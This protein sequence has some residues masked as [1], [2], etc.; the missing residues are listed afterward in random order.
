MA[1]TPIG[2]GLGTLISPAS[3]VAPA[4]SGSASAGPSLVVPWEAVAPVSGG[5]DCS[6][7][8]RVGLG[9]AGGGD[10]GLGE[11]GDDGGGGFVGGPN[12]VSFIEH[13]RVSVFVEFHVRNCTSHYLREGPPPDP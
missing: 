10:G 1:W 9:S 5:L 2:F 13:S 3:L 4:T 7:L 8:V 11:G 6:Y 12:V